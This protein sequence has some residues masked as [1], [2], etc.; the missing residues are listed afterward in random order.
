MA[1]GGRS[2]FYVWRITSGKPL[3]LQAIE[4]TLGRSDAA[5]RV[6]A[7]FWYGIGSLTVETNFDPV[8]SCIGMMRAGRTAIQMEM[9]KKVVY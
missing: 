3:A 7:T 9:E 1:R 4:R 6:T 5:R 8:E 2:S